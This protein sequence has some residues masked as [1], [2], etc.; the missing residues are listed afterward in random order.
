[1]ER[2]EKYRR[3][4]R[5]LHWVHTGAFLAL[6]IT[7]IFLYFPPWGGL[8]EDNITRMVHRLGAVVFVLAPLIYM[9]M[10]WKGFTVIYYG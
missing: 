9:F 8:A 2:V 7:G 3:Q 5:I 6:I 10:N 1:M 4:T